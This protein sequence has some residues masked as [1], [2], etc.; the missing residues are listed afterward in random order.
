MHCRKFLVSGLLV[1]TALV[2]SSCS[3][4]LGTFT[5]VSTHNVRNLD[6]SIENNSKAHV[7]GDTCIHHILLIP[8][9]GPRE[10]RLNRAIDDAIANGHKGGL[11]GDLLVNVRI[12]GAFWTTILYG[13]QCIDVE[14]DLVKVRAMAK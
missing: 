8:L 4:R 10:D 11:D 12:D 14:G 13:R 6:Y 1:C 9:W 2:L 5:A 3:V 7:Q